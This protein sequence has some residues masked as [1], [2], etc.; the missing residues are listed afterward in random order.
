MRNA[1]TRCL[2]IARCHVRDAQGREDG[3]ACVASQLSRLERN[4]Q[5][6]MIYPDCHPYGD[7]P[8]IVAAFDTG[9]GNV[10][11][12]VALTGTDRCSRDKMNAAGRLCFQLLA[13]C[14]APADV[15]GVPPDPVCVADSYDRLATKFAKSEARGNC[16]TTGDAADVQAAVQAAVD[17]SVAELTQP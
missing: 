4:F 16:T 7:P 17:S 12:T 2:A 3:A 10:A 13:N 9:M 8:D 14:E 11:T 1:G 15:A 6:T 5:E